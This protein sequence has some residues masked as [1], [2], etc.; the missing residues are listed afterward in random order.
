MG[1]LKV[2][3]DSAE[4][5]ISELSKLNQLKIDYGINDGEIKSATGAIDK[6]FNGNRQN[7]AEAT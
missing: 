4:D 2:V 5:A 3:P 6:A 7:I 1:M